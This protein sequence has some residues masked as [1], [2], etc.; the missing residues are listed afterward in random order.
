MR[1]RRGADPPRTRQAIL[2][3]RYRSVM[4]WLSVTEIA[5]LLAAGETEINAEVMALPPR[6]ATWHPAEGGW[7][8][9]ECL[10]HLIEA[11]RR[12]FAGRIRT[13]RAHGDGLALT[14]WDQVEV[15]RTR[16]DCAANTRALLDEFRLERA[17]SVALVR[18]LQ[19]SDLAL[20]GEHPQVG[21]LTLGDV[22]AEW[23]Y[24]DRNHFK[25]MLANVQ[26]FAWQQMGN[27]QRFSLP[28]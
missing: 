15:A 1:R 10:G 24:H 7:C 20:G 2:S 23:T 9:N 17:T 28:H 26:G 5:S 11:E 4:D 3:S 19:P 21:H 8:V 13:M 25:Q 14:S 6:V 27:A 18:S 22:L 12:G 16:S